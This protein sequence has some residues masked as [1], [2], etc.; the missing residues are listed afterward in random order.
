MSGVVVIGAGQAAAELASS[1]RE[2]GYQD[3]I[4]LVGEEPWLPY[5]RPPLS[6]KFLAERPAP[7][8]LYLRPASFWREKD[9]TIDLGTA[10]TAIEREKRKLALADG[11]AIEY[12]T[13]VLAIGARARALPLPGIELAGVFFLRR[14]EDVTRLRPALDQARRV[15]IVGGGY[16]GLEVAAVVRG[17]GREVAVIEAEERLMQ[18]VTSP[19]VSAFYAKLH[20]ERGVDLR[21]NAKLAAIE[22]EKRASAVRL[23]G[24]EEI[25][26]DLV[27][28][29][30]GAR[31]NDEL[32]DRAGLACED[33]ILVD[34]HAR[35]ADP[36][37]YAIGDCAR[38]PSRRFGRRVRLECVQNA[39]DQG[40][41]AAAAIL[42]RDEPYDPVPW[43]WSDQ[44]EV[45]FQSAGLAEGHDDRKVVGDPASARFSV[46]YRK[47]GRLI[48]IDAVNDG[49]AYMT[50]R[51][52]IAQETA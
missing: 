7:D 15:A 52:R 1:L 10:V 48:A 30:T 33:G 39:F 26:A 27:L 31:A 8:T 4:R 11:R 3:P 37:I 49:R 47:A 21:L 5:Q 43:F 35:T 2:G 51:R 24:G 20:R 40:K 22:G 9:V 32:A 16:I 14:I 50:G 23:A 19:P 18:R 12:E 17:E 29:A 38:F 13:L 28:V 6:K 36:A 41:S 25:A 42:G 44:Y 45:K 46:E 34:A